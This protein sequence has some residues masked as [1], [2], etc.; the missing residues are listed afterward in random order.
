MTFNLKKFLLELIGISLAVL[1]FI[2]LVAHFGLKSNRSNEIILGYVISLVIFV[3]GFISINWSFSRSLKTFM[4]IVLGGMFLRFVLI[5]VALFLLIR[6]ANIHL[7]SFILA[8]FIFYFIYQI[9]EIRF[10]NS[11]LSK[12]KKWLHV[13]KDIA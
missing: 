2:L 3:L 8:F 5:G 1:L 4:G 6:Y 9:Y 10:I 7:L 11:K 12:G 13:F